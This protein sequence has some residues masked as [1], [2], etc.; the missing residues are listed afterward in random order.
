MA[1]QNA[2]EIMIADELRQLMPCG[3]CNLIPVFAKRRH[4]ELKVKRLIDILLRCGGNQILSAVEAVR[5]E[6]G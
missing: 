1:V 2:I 4:N 3:P 5:P 6:V